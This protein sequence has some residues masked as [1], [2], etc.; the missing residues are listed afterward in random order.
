MT[1]EIAIA[2]LGAD[3]EDAPAWKALTRAVHDLAR[4]LDAPEDAA[5]DVL[6]KLFTLVLV[7]GADALPCPAEKTTA[8]LR[9]MVRNRAI[10]L[11]HREGAGTVT[12]EHTIQRRAV[13]ATDPRDDLDQE[14]LMLLD[15]AARAVLR[16]REPRHRDAFASAW[17]Q[18]R[19]WATTDRSLTE[20]IATTEGASPADGPAWRRAQDK[21]H[22][23][24]RRA[25]EAVHERLG[26]LERTGRMSAD[27][28]TVARQAL[29]ALVYCPKRGHK[30]VTRTEDPS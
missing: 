14:A 21:V 13:A 22:K 9:S 4:S 30:G 8:Y 23:A 26:F 20:I 1:P 25:R 7:Q 10:D 29:A 18:I 27:D 16:V 6:E 24:H 5:A 12:D 28:A 3:P 15:E 2:R 17:A 11:Y 19:A